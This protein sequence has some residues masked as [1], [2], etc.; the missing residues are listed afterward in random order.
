MKID[1]KNGS[2]TRLTNGHHLVRIVGKTHLANLPGIVCKNPQAPEAKR[3]YEKRF[4][5]KRIY[6][7]FEA[8]IARESILGRT[9]EDS[10]VLGMTGYSSIKPEDCAAWGIQPEAYEAACQEVLANM[11][12]AIRTEYPRVNIAIADGASDL[13]VDQAV[14]GVS[15]HLNLPHLGH[16]CPNYMMYVKDDHDTVLVSNTQD[17]YSDEFIRSLD[18]LC[19]VGGRLQ[20]LLH[21]I[22]AAILF[23]KKVLLFDLVR[24]I[25]INRGGPAARGADGG[26]HDA[27]SAFLAAIRLFQ[28]E[29]Q[30]QSYEAMRDWVRDQTVKVT[31]P[32]VSP[33]SAFSKWQ[34]DL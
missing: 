9:R 3:I 20:A 25:S 11:V 28:G 34:R 8:D 7:P 4:T 6:L 30:T 2:I 18:I 19:S 33:Q 21:D 12:L 10:I 29:N 15:R 22:K 13:G 26:V 1:P 27:T 32:L 5:Q 14:I 23:N 16:S 24:T 31:R 17:E